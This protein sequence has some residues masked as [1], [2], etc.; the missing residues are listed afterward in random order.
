MSLAYFCSHCNRPC[1]CHSNHEYSR[2]DFFSHFIYLRCRCAQR[3]VVIPS[4]S[5][6]PLSAGVVSRLY[7]T[8]QTPWSESASE[9]YRPSDRRLSTKWLPTFADKGC[10]VVSVTDPYDRIFGFL[11]RSRYFS[12][13]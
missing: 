3:R 6:S 1:H 5:L 7:T 11:D 4:V 9:L 2:L 10:H 8:K 13:K 12:I